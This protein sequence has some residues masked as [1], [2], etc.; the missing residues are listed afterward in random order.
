MAHTIQIL[1]SGTALVNRIILLV[2]T[3]RFLSGSRLNWLFFQPVPRCNAPLPC[4]RPQ[5]T[6]TNFSSRFAAYIT[7]SLP[8]HCRLTAY[9]HELFPAGSWNVEISTFHFLTL[10]KWT[11]IWLICWII[12][13]FSPIFAGFLG[14]FHKALFPMFRN[15]WYIRL[16]KR[17]GYFYHFFVIRLT[18]ALPSVTMILQFFHNMV[19]NQPD[20]I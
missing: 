3:P 18:R 13:S 5:P 8:D 1:T 14:Y 2:R 15:P 11:D 9:N 6:I 10:W 4:P 17:L 19:F 7:G 12:P 20:R 16:R